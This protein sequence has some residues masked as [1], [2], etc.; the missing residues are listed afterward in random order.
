MADLTDSV[1]QEYEVI[2]A[3]QDVGNR[4]DQNNFYP[5]DGIDISDQEYSEIFG[6]KSKKEG[7]PGLLKGLFQRGKTKDTQQGLDRLQSRLDRRGARAGFRAKR[8]QARIDARQARRMASLPPAE[9]QEVGNIA[10]STPAVAVPVRK[11]TEGVATP[12]EEQVAVKTT[13]VAQKIVQQ[14]D[15]LDTQAVKEVLQEVQTPQQADA[16]LTDILDPNTNTGKAGWK[17]MSTGVKVAIIGGGLA[18]VGLIT[19]LIIKKGK[20]SSPKA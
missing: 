2:P 14:V 11:A 15:D 16:V 3:N 1:V 9:K 7:G 20:S 18:V 12:Q 6:I 10:S 4:F 13:Q 8:R 17:G 19:Y 5:M